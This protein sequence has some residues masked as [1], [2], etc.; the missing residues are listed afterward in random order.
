MHTIKKIILI[1]LMVGALLG[2]FFIPAFGAQVAIILLLLSGILLL[3]AITIKHPFCFYVCMT[4]FSLSVPL[5]VLESYYFIALHNYKNHFEHKDLEKTHSP[6][7]KVNH[8][9][10]SQEGQ[11]NVSTQ[12]DEKQYNNNYRHISSKRLL[13]NG[14]VLY[15]VTY[16]LN[17]Y[18]QRIT[19]EHPHAKNAVVFLGCSFTFGDGLEDMQTFPWLVGEKLGAD[20]QVYNL[21]LSGHGTHHALERLER[22]L[23]ALAKYHNIAVFYTVIED[24]QRRFQ[25]GPQYVLEGDGLKR[26]GNY[27]KIK[28]FWSDTIW[29]SWLQRSYLFKKI[30]VPLKDVLAPLSKREDRVY[31]L[32]ALTRHMQKEL[33]TK[34]PHS[35]FTVLAWP[36]HSLEMLAGLPQNIHVIDVERWLPDYATEQFKEDSKYI[37]YPKVDSHP[38]AYAN[39]LVS[40][41]LVTVIREHME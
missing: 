14:K 27:G 1:I 26:Q 31:L 16:T 34:Y 2:M 37:I 21:A 38:T 5:A 22:Q 7:G 35:M 40:N 4:F 17:E 18:G 15:N 24:H 33:Y 11:K 36:P 3:V 13:E 25:Y 29:E 8:T 20:Y 32:H 12:K 10:T 6:K 39:E 23:P 28:F 9:K 19:P 30:E 41:A